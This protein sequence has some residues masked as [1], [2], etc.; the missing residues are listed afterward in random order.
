M[1]T[2][3]SQNTIILWAEVT[4]ILQ[5]LREATS[6]HLADNYQY[7][8]DATEKGGDDLYCFLERG[9]WAEVNRNPA[10]RESI[11]IDVENLMAWK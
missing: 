2:I 5:T 4:E 9:A 3:C 8:T 11:L 7:S 1:I 6:S 10:D